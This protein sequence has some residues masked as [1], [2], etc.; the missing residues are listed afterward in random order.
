MLPVLYVP[1][2]TPPSPDERPP[3]PSRRP[4]FVLAAA[5]LA[6]V[7]ILAWATTSGGTTPTPS[8]ATVAT[9]GDAPIRLAEAPIVAPSGPATSGG[10]QPYLTGSEPVAKSEPKPAATPT[11]A[12]S[13][14]PPAPTASAPVA[15]APE[16]AA[17]PTAAAT[18][19]GRPVR[20]IDL[21][22]KP[23]TEPAAT[24]KPASVTPVAP[25][26]PAAPTVVA[27]PPAPPAPA[28]KP[29]TAVVAPPKPSVT[30]A[31]PIDEPPL[32]VAPITTPSEVRTTTEMPSA[33]TA[34]VPPL[35]PTVAVPTQTP[36]VATPAQTPAATTAAPTVGAP[37]TAPQP[38]PPAIAGTEPPA[39][40]AVAKKLARTA[41]PKPSE[42][43]VAPR[44]PTAGTAE[45][46]GPKPVVPGSTASRALGQSGDFA[47]RLA[48]VRR[49]E[50]R[51]LQAPSPAWDD[52][53]IVES[54]RRRGW[55]IIP[56]FFDDGPPR[57]VLRPFEPPP[58]LASE[59]PVGHSNCHFH[60]WP[61]E[62]MEFH[63]AVECHWHR[64]A[65]DPSLRYVR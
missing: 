20:V 55:S 41:E 14:T 52:E 48:T 1:P 54:P 37:L 32:A 26:A 65:R 56:P 31:Q 51:R 18:A 17:A 23:D 34:P 60:A 50:A 3:R 2:V 6:G 22:R 35:A 53:E 43:K 58:R 33:A 12:T 30:T 57:P 61:T 27:E 38:T 25:A 13:V 8:M 15:A 59:R 16:P 29:A 7:T 4:Q 9:A 10:S 40:A 24:P 11:A 45:T 28:T 62:D 64:N 44:K 42:P 21:D 36:E 5:L 39:G 46:T 63:R 49:D 19:D 47:D